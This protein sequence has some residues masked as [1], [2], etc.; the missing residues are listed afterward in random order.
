MEPV[1]NPLQKE[2]SVS[3]PELSLKT[4]HIGSLPFLEVERALEVAF[5]FD[6]P[7]WPQLPKYREEGM[8]FQFVLDFPS[9]D[10]ETERVNTLDP[11]FEEGMLK[12]Y[13][14]YLEV[15]EKG[16]LEPLFELF[17]LNFS[18]TF[19]AFLERAKE[20]KTELIKGQITGPFTLGISLKTDTNEILIFRDDLRDLL[21][22]FITL[23]ALYQALHLKKVASQVILFFDEPGLSG[24]GS[25]AYISLSKELVVELLR[26]PIQ[27]LKSFGILIGFHVCANTSW[28]L[29]F[30]AEPHIVNFDSFSY[31]DR[32]II[33]PEKLAEFLYKEGTYLAFGAVPTNKEA[34][35]QT[36]ENEIKKV[37][38]EQLKTLEERLSV[39]REILL[40]KILFTPACGLGSLPEELVPKVIN[41]LEVL[42]NSFKN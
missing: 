1:E 3:Y 22:K 5:S 20:K 11:A 27:I 12:I 29:L 31:F 9:F 36:N 35:L 21:L 32:F 8:I 14:V 4:T 40:K 38:E 15:T 33:Y 42:K 28:D 2:G 41:L 25:S 39:S 13:E 26:E 16:N 6:I 34:L 37:F 10:L 7:A 24:F 19:K 30:E 17:N 23:K 18:K